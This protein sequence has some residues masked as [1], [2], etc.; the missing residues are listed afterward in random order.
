MADQKQL[1][2]TV[3]CSQAQVLVASEANAGLDVS[4]GPGQCAI[5]AVEAQRHEPPWL[6]VGLQVL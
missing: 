5:D 4:L 6:L 1:T 3:K 2:K